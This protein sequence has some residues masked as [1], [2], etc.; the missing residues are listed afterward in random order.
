MIQSPPRAPRRV[1]ASWMTSLFLSLS[2][3][4]AS[5]AV[6]NVNVTI[7]DAVDTNP[8]DGIC[9]ISSGDFCTLRAAVME[10]NQLPGTD[11]I[12]LPGS[13]TITLSIAGFDNTPASG[14]LDILDNVI[15]GTFT[16]DETDYPTIDAGALNNR[17][18]EIHSSADQVTL[19]RFRLTGG[20]ATDPSN[21]GLGGAINIRSSVDAVTLNSVELFANIAEEGGAIYNLGAEL[22][23]SDSVIRNNASSESGA[24]LV[25]DCGDVTITQSSIHDNLTLSG[26]NDAIVN[27]PRFNAQNA[28][29][30]LELRNS[31]VINNGGVGINSEGQGSV[32]LSH[33]TLTGHS[34]AGIRVTPLDIDDPLPTLQLRQTVLGDNSDSNCL[35]GL[36]DLDIDGFNLADNGSCAFALDDSNQIA[37]PLL[38]PSQAAP[39]RWHRIRLPLA[40][41]PAID[42]GDSGL[43]NECDPLDQLGTERPLDGD[44]NGIARCDIGA[45]EFRRLPEAVFSDGF[46]SG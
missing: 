20:D 37:K 44:G 39:G 33:V 18:F 4:T 5:A 9:R 6:F 17:I 7:F 25:N 34:N 14:D 35:L 22:E 42:R 11:I 28:V 15:I 40:G 12:V 27:A 24:A 38:G 31:T 36:V 21:T 41:S 3:A 45:I 1:V 46:E 29:C 26:L 10:A 43:G 19:Q 8:G 13:S 32:V 30:S 2:A 23:I 16:V